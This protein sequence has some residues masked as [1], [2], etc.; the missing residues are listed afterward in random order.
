[1]PKFN[2]KCVVQNGNETLSG[3][4]VELSA[5][6]GERLVKRR[7]AT[8]CDVVA[9]VS[10]AKTSAEIKAEAKAQAKAKAEAEAELKVEAEAEAQKALEAGTKDE[11]GAA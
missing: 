1:M 8:R 9:T 10:K 6:V 11:G 4:G 2:L 7:L 5:D 3:N